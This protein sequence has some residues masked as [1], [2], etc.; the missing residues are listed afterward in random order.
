MQNS[1][2]SKIYKPNI[3]LTSN[4]RTKSFKIAREYL[5]NLPQKNKSH[6]SINIQR[7]D[8]FQK[9]INILDQIWNE[10]EITYQYREA[11]SIYLKSMKD[12][13]KNNLIFQEKNNLKKYKKALLNLKKEISIREDNILL[14]KQYNNRLDT[15]NTN[16]QIKSI[17]DAVINLVKKLRIN[18]I[19][20]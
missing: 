14:L 16:E 10:F 11:F 4:D 2:S 1:Y 7:E 8:S 20:K 5:P 19:Q 13:Y 18:A 12:E 6:L 3:Y 15:F 17:I 9:E